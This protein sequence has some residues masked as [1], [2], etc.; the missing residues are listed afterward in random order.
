FTFT[1][2]LSIQAYAQVF[3]AS[4]DYGQKMLGIPDGSRIHTDRLEPALDLSD[5]YDFSDTALNISTVLRWEYLPGS[6]LYLVYTGSF[7]FDQDVA[8]F[9]FGPLL[10]DLLEGESSHVLMMKLSYLWD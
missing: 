8:D 1:T 2:T 7:S 9:R 6:L 3:L 4:V 10:A 5:D